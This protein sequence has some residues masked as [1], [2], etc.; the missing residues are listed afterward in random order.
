MALVGQYRVV[1]QWFKV[2]DKGVR[3]VSCEG[4]V[5]KAIGN[6]LPLFVIFLV[7]SLIQIHSLICG[8][9]NALIGGTVPLYP[10]ISQ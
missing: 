6:L 8:I 5:T 1:E 9:L 4:K 7:L 2:I 10:R 3:H